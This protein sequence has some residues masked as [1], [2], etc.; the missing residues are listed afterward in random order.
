MKIYDKL[1]SYEIV[2]QF[3]RY[4]TIGVLNVALF[5]AIYNGLRYIKVEAHLAYVIGFVLTSIGSFFLNKRWAF[6]D[7]HHQVMRQYLKFVSF[8][9]V[10]LCISTGAFSAFLHWT[11]LDQHGRLGE[12]IAAL[13]AVP[14]S[15]VW[16]FF[17]YRTWTFRHA[18]TAGAA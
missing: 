7:P 1:A 12:N 17:S 2:G 16:N 15:V 13:A 5:L 3:V 14:F 18:G 11:P 10:G 8:T 4:A 9:A 6:R